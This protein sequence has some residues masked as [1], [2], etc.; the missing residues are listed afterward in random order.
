MA[1]SFS[2]S[3]RSG[4]NLFAAARDAFGFTTASYG[5]PCLAAVIATQRGWALI[6]THF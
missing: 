4:Q 1:K 2:T 3:P 6:E 5:L